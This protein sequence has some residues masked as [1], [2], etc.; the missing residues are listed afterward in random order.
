MK[1]ATKEITVFAISRA[2]IDPGTKGYG[3]SVIDPDAESN[4]PLDE[5]TFASGYAVPVKVQIP[6]DWTVGETNSGEPMLFASGGTAMQL[7]WYYNK[8]A[9]QAW[10]A[11]ATLDESLKHGSAIVLSAQKLSQVG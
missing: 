1:I 6:E 10:P 3:I 8:G 11:F 9:M 4:K 7:H 5:R 2:N